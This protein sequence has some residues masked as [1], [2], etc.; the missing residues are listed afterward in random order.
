[1]TSDSIANID[2]EKWSEK[3]RPLDSELT[4]G[5]SA[6]FDDFVFSNRNELRCSSR[7][8]LLRFF[9]LLKFHMTNI[10]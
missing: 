1:M 3:N 9:V 4:E 6:G 7:P 2:S 10:Y 8:N 5:F